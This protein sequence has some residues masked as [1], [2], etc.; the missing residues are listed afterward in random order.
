MAVLLTTDGVTKT[1]YGTDAETVD[2]LAAVTTGMYSLA[3]GAGQHLNC[4]GRVRQVI[5]ELNGLMLYI[6]AAGDGSRLLVVADTP[7]DPAAIGYEMADLRKKVAAHLAT[8]ARN[9][10]REAQA[11]ERTGTW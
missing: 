4:D 1:H 3:S 11:E 6:S 7:A 10:S 8:P 5:A 9:T 2:R